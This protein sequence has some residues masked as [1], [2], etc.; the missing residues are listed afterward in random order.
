MKRV[1]PANPISRRSVLKAAAAL[2]GAALSQS[3]PASAASLNWTRPQAARWREERGWL[4][5]CNFIPSTAVNQLEMWQADTFDGPTIDREL[6]W[7]ADLGFTSVRLFLHDLLWS[8]PKA[9]LARLDQFLGIAQR[10]GIGALLVLFDGVWHPEPKAG[11]QAPP[12]PHLHNPGWLQ[13]PGARILA[14]A[15]RQKQLEGYVRGVIERFRD[16]DRIHG[17]DLFNEPDNLNKKSYPHLELK[18]KEARA[19]QLL[20]RTF[21]WARAERP[22]QPLTA[23]VWNGNWK[24]NATLRPLQRLMLDQSDVISFHSY[25]APER[26][27]EKIAELSRYGRPLLCTE[28]MARPQKSTFDPSLEILARHGVGAYGWGFVSG[29]TQTIYPWDSWTQTYTKA[30]EVW[31]HDI[32]DASGKPHDPAEV[33]YIKRITG[34]RSPG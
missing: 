2:P 27:E 24:S 21:A 33:A 1:L 4:V 11:R 15:K 16:D 5:G 20:R 18:D 30:P 3:A 12:R 31:F 29:K 23:G 26:L 19:M 25:D 22:R 32:F 28:F 6:G 7:A 13:S 8:E 9:F 14:S 17:W 34:R 10:H